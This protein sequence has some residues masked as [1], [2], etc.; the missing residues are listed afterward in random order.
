MKFDTIELDEAAA[1]IET[2]LLALSSPCSA[3][4]S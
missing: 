2:L 1:F 4:G 3:L